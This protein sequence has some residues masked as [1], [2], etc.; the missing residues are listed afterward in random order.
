ML[1][2]YKSYAPRVT[3]SSTYIYCTSREGAIEETSGRFIK[4][5]KRRLQKR[6]L[7]VLVST[8]TVTTDIKRQNERIGALADA[9]A[10]N[11][12]PCKQCAGI[13]QNQDCRGSFRSEI[14]CKDPSL[15]R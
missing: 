8:L 9:I 2:R 1:A 14:I 6:K 13:Y 5:E 10:H 11:L 15:L 12:R 7:L 4:E 3:T